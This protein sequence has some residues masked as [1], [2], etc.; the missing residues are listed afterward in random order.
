MNNQS[1][2]PDPFTRSPFSLMLWSGI[3]HR[4]WNLEHHLAALY[5]C[6][7]AIFVCQFIFWGTMCYVIVTLREAAGTL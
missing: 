5:W 2:P 3:L 1:S 4:K 7:T 6:L